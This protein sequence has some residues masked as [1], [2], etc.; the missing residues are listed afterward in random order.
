M[1]DV[2]K[3]IIWV[4]ILAVSPIFSQKSDIH[5]YSID[6]GLPTNTVND[7]LQDKIGYLWIATNKGYTKFDGVYFTNYQQNKANCIF[8][9]NNTT[10]I[11]L[12]NGLVVIRNNKSSF[13]ESKE[14][15]K[16]RKINNKIVLATTQGICFFKKDYVQPLQI[17]SQIDFS[18]INDIIIT[19][20]N[21]YVAAK[22]GLWSIETLY[23][24]KKVFK[25]S[26]NHFTSLLKVNRTL[27]AGT[28]TNGAKI[29]QENNTIKNISSLE[30][31]TDLQKID[32]E[33]WVSSSDNGIE[34]LDAKKITFK[35]LINKYN[36]PISNK[37]NGIYKNN[38]N[39]IWLATNNK[40]LCK[41]ALYNKQQSIQVPVFLENVSVN[42][43]SLDSLNIKKLHLEANQNNISFTYKSIHLKNPKNTEYQYQLNNKKSPWSYKNSV[44]F[45]N[46]QSGK[47]TFTVQ[48][49]NNNIL[50]NK[51]RFNFIIDT[52]F[53]KKYWFAILLCC[54]IFTIIAFFIDLKL[55]RIKKQNQKEVLQLK[56][57]KHLLS[58]EQKALQLQMNPHF[59]FNVL[60]GIKALGN[61]GNTLEL[62]KTISQFSVLLRSVLNNSRLEEISLDDE[63]NT[64]KNYLAL[65]KKMSTVTFEYEIEK[66]LNN[67]DSEEILI[68]PM[69][70]QPFIEN[71][72]KHAFNANS[73]NPCITIKFK[74]ENQF[75]AFCIKDN[76]IGYLQSK[77]NTT[78][79]T[80]HKSL[81][82][83]VTKERIENLSKHHCF[84]IHEIV[85]GT[86]ITGTKVT[87]K[88]PLKTDY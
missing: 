23:K 1:I 71:S 6:K 31:I 12:T 4:V 50:S 2:L 59:I 14:I 73:K 79:H 55:K 80:S 60:N 32:N 10:Y 58:L 61:S 25:L 70:L 11:G 41:Y 42:Y 83:K 78:T 53:Y 68:P 84:S 27:L 28:F 43:A 56:Q 37:I 48:S 77:K 54:V 87:F 17:N 3:T 88:I 29:I 22:T 20:H 63:I 62:N 33:I 9:D 52:P 65:E 26:N 18:L 36:S 75:L 49:K 8:T 39:T 45:A 72:I 67:I 64:L 5:F 47:Y 16:I 21:I 34:V 81:A 86:K 69:L 7:V 46:L 44:D 24:P 51:V 19:K 74:V 85:D 35:R 15:L 40:G 66:K 30:K 13:F 38:N 57:E 82:L 76:G